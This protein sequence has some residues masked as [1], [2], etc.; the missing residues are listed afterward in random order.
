MSERLFSSQNLIRFLDR[1]M[2]FDKELSDSLK[3]K[4]K[5]KQLK[6]TMQINVFHSTI[7]GNSKLFAEELT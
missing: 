2:K 1:W 5:K 7:R 3:K 4:K 6:R